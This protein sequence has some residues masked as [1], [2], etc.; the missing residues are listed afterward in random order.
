MLGIY[1]SLLDK[2]QSMKDIDEMDILYYFDIL[3][4]RIKKEEFN[5]IKK[6]DEAGL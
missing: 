2:G 3:L 4:Y 1:E 6:Y 5:V